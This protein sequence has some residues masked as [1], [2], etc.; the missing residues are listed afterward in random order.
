MLSSPEPTQLNGRNSVN[1]R[2]CSPVG[3][4]DAIEQLLD[5]G[6]DPALLVDGT[7][8]ELGGLGIELLVAARAIDL[9]GRGK[10]HALLVFDAVADDG[11]V[12][13]EIQLEHAQRLAHVGRGRGDRHE[14]QNHVALSHVIF[15][16]FLVDG[17]VALDEVEA[18]VT[19]E[20]PDPLGLQIHAVDRPVRIFQDVLAQMVADEA[21]DPENENVFQDEPLKY[22]R[23]ANASGCFDKAR[24]A[25]SGAIGT[26][27]L[28]S[29]LSAARAKSRE[30]ERLVRQGRGRGVRRDRPLAD[31]EPE[32]LQAP[33]VECNRHTS[34]AF[35]VQARRALG[36]ARRTGLDAGLEHLEA[37]AVDLG[38]CARERRRHGA[39]Q[40]VDGARTRAPIDA[41][42][43]RTAAAEIRALGEIERAAPRRSRRS[44]SEGSARSTCCAASATFID[45]SSAVS[46]SQ[47]RDGLLVDQRPRVRLLEH[48]MQARAR[49]ASR[50]G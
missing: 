20:R 45:T 14:R 42:V 24:G 4:D 41:P 22:R 26:P 36:M 33:P 30:S 23:A 47:D 18:F 3:P 7:E 21:V 49:N 8:H 1:C 43:L 11:Q 29:F 39:H 50:R 6:I 27:P 37:H 10:H 28:A 46:F 31:R 35:G 13:L 38:E 34:A 44:T 2:P 5:A 48:V 25:A 40:V 15:D 32:N 19:E 17:D 16:P 9:G 12:R